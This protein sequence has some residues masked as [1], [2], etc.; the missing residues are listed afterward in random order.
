MKFSREIMIFLLLLFIP[1]SC[2]GSVKILD[3]EAFAQTQQIV[4]LGVVSNTH[5][6]L[7]A[8]IA[9]L[10][11]LEKELAVGIELGIYP[12][13]KI[14]LEEIFKG[15][16]DIVIVN[17]PVFS[18]YLA[19][20]TQPQIEKVQVATAIDPGTAT[21]FLALTSE[22]FA[23]HYPTLTAILKDTSSSLS[24]KE[25]S[26]LAPALSF[27]SSPEKTILSQNYPNPFNPQTTIQYYTNKDDHI[28]LKIYDLKGE[29]IKT[30][31][32]EYQTAGYYTITWPGD[33]DAGGEVPSGVYFCRITAADFVSTKKMVVLK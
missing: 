19:S 33:T 27:P 7:E 23:Y 32:D 25:L 24:T 20:L 13:N 8:N 30:L 10:E 1:S 17:E 3:S 15:T 5:D 12:T 14:L 16:L 9:L 26:G 22:N 4:K 21:K 29:V 18:E 2:L 31:V 6:P 28:R 11:R